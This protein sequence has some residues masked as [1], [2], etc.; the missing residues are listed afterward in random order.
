MDDPELGGSLTRSTLHDLL[1]SERRRVTLSYLVEH[2]SLAL[3]DLADEIA[4]H[5]HDG[6]LS[7]IPEENVLRIYLTLYH[8][9]IPKLS[10]AGVVAYDQASDRVALAENADLLKE[11][12]SLDTPQESS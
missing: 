1:S 4:R 7:Q 5:E 2:G 8:K 3:P 6:A 10:R 12:S 11:H 9:H